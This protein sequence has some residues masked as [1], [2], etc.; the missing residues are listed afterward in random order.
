MIIHADRTTDSQAGKECPLIS[1]VPDSSLPDRIARLARLSVPERAR[2]MSEALLVCSPEEAAHIAPAL[3]QLALR[4]DALDAPSPSRPARGNAT[5]STPDGKPDLEALRARY[6]L[7]RSGSA[8]PATGKP[9]LSSSADI[10]SHAFHT[11][12]APLGFFTRV[13]RWFRL[14]RAFDADAALVELARGW[15]GVPPLARDAA[16]ALGS[17]RWHTVAHV[18]TDSRPPVLRG[19]ALLAAEAADAR[20]I[21]WPLAAARSADPQ[22]A[23]AARWSLFTLALLARPLAPLERDTWLAAAQRDETWRRLLS[24][25]FARGLAGD[26]HSVHTAIL[27]ALQD[28]AAC[29]AAAEAALLALPR[30]AHTAFPSLPDHVQR[31]LAAAIK[32][33]RA[34]FVRVRA[35]E[36][37]ASARGPLASACILRLARSHGLT[38]H[39]MVLERAC[40]AMRPA[41][42]MSLHRVIVRGA[43]RTTRAGATLDLTATALPNA[44]EVAALSL[45]A[46]R[47]LPRW[48]ANINADAPTRERALEP[49]LNHR[50]DA[51]RFAAAFHGPTRL[52]RDFIFDAD[53]RIARHAFLRTAATARDSAPVDVSAAVR[54][55][56]AHVASLA[57]AHAARHAAAFTPSPGGRLAALRWYITDRESCSKTLRWMLMQSSPA[58]AGRAITV[59]RRIAAVDAFLSELRER[60]GMNPADQSALHIA[61]AACAALGDSRDP[62]AASAVKP[63]FTHPDAR[64]RANAVEA[65]AHLA[66]RGVLPL[67]AEILELKTDQHHRIRANALRESLHAT[68]EPRMQIAVADD[69]ASMLSDDRPLHRLAG[70]WLASR[71]LVG[72]T[73]SILRAR[74]TEMSNRISTLASSDTDPRVRTR[75]AACATAAAALTRA[76]WIASAGDLTPAAPAV[77]DMESMLGQPMPSDAERTTP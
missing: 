43:R 7:S 56:H 20:C 42:V 57:A 77:F 2:V 47:S 66:R 16:I 4:P 15:L 12:T 25:G 62:A 30:A 75:A 14:D 74:W 35:L 64:V 40:L 44:G 5:P 53:P 46:A 36:L 31:A 6:G 58:D 38:D 29:E 65:A 21:A 27:R 8:D 55:P 3:M 32:S 71:T 69:L 23:D 34:P 61:S 51:A 59:I 60:A 49:Y 70:L 54:S 19:L 26:A 24:R 41:R 39:H 10:G 11:H 28:P 18:L 63:L 72:P 37:L 76:S 48:S 33:L 1:T 13:Q 52:A 73:R 17:G 22:V 50:D 45:D 9:A 68:V 67:P